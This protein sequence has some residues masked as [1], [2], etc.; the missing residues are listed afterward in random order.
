MLKNNEFELKKINTRTKSFIIIIFLFFSIITSRVFYLQIVKGS[1][2]KSVAEKNII[3]ENKLLP[4]RGNIYDVDGK[5]I[6]GNKNIYSLFVLPEEIKGF[7]GNKETRKKA[8]ETFIDLLSKKIDIENK[9]ELLN[10]ILKARTYL[11]FNI[12]SNLTEEELK[13]LMSNK[14][15]LDG[16]RFKSE[17]VRHYPDNDLFFHIVGYVSKSD[18]RDLEIYSDIDILL[19]SYIGKVGIEKYFN[20]ELYGK[21]GLEEIKI[22]AHGRIKSK[23]LIKSPEK[24]KDI[25]L[26]LD[27][28]IQL[29]AKEELKHKGAIVA[30]NAKTGD[31]I[32]YYSNPTYDPNKFVSGLTR[33]DL[34]YINS[35]DSPLIDRIIQGQYPPA[36]TIKPFI[37]LAAMVGQYITGDRV[38][39]CGPHYQIGTHRFRDWVKQGHGDTDM[40]KS[41]ARSVDVYYYR[42]GHEMGVDYMHDFLYQYGFG[43]KVPFNLK[44]NQ[45]IGLLPN[46]HWK[47]KMHN[48][49]FYPG[50]EVIIA[51][52][53]G[54]FLITP[55]QLAYATKLLVNN[56]EKYNLNFIKGKSKEIIGKINAPKEHLEYVKQGLKEVVHG[57]M[58]TA[59]DIRKFIKYESGGKTGTAQVFSTRGEIDYDNAEIPEH[60]RDHGWYMGFAPYDDPEIVVVVLTENSGGGGSNSAPIAAKI[61]NLYLDKKE[62]KKENKKDN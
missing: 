38:V 61:M 56:G 47:K 31:I 27:R 13:I 32:A 59:R 9:E 58:G 45:Q 24:G 15:Y 10:K 26:T 22:N 62:L 16:L 50:E 36:S 51:I 52:G 2:F 53:Q 25:Y 11:E 57:R 21:N 34:E 44:Q 54:Q 49:P 12:K 17:T 14:D 43:Q 8:I 4:E 19:N 30:L 48:E 23:D 1:E 37:G 55:L 28:D 18:R 40:I 41:I 42:L 7:K 35:K 6:A 20:R 60:L 29:L 5:L 3:R 39:R 46:N 33:K